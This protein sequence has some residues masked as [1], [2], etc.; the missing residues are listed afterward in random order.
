MSQTKQPTTP[1]LEAGQPI[2]PNSE[3]SKDRFAIAAWLDTANV[4]TFVVCVAASIGYVLL[5]NEVFPAIWAN[6]NTIVGFIF[7]CIKIVGAVVTFKCTEAC[8]G[9]AVAC[10][11][12]LQLLVQGLQKLEQKRDRQLG[13]AS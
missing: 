7:T 9:M 8:V 10:W 1:A 13:L 11:G 4:P 3:Q 12:L 2:Y 6:P 5:C